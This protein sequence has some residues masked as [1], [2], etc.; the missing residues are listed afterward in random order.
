MNNVLSLFTLPVGLM[1]VGGVVLIITFVLWPRGQGFAVWAKRVGAVV[2]TLVGVGG[3]ATTYHASMLRQQTESTKNAEAQKE[4]ASIQQELS[5]A[6][7]AN[8]VQAAK[9]TALE[10]TA[11]DQR[12][13]DAERPR[14]SKPTCRRR[15]RTSARCSTSVTA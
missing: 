7:A 8:R 14:S 10:R 12:Q 5:N 6:L 3:A 1:T 4:M 2:F 9:L 13:R 11:T 15:C